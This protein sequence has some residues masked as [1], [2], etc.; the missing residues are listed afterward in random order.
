MDKEFDI[1]EY[2]AGLTGFVFDKAVLR[3]VA[4][5]RDVLGVENV[6]DLDKRT[7]DLLLADLLFVVYLSPN[8]SASLTQQHGAYSQT[9]GSQTIQSKDDIYNIL[10]S[11]YKK[12]GDDKLEDVNEA[13][14][15]LQWLF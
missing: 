3:R 8:S 9:V 13:R 1:L 12:Y 7:R 5:E 15:S 14:G 10:Y 6:K 2:L 11:I 4:M